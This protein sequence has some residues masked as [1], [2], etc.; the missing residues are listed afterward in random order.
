MGQAVLTLE[1]KRVWSRG[2]TF[3]LPLHPIQVDVSLIS[4]LIALVSCAE[5]WRLSF[6]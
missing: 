2:G 4:F 1:H 6:A 3:F 5:E